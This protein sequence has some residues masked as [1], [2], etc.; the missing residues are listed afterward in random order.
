MNTAGGNLADVF[1][2]P[3]GNG[4]ESLFLC[5]EGGRGE[6]DMKSNKKD[7][8]KSFFVPIIKILIYGM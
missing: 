7:I 8:W 4:R 2:W 6:G 1:I 5:L 3:G